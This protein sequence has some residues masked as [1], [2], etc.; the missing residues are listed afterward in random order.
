MSLYERNESFR[1]ESGSAFVNITL[2]Q[3][4]F[5]QIVLL[6]GFLQ[7]PV[8]LRYVIKHRGKLTREG[9]LLVLFFFLYCTFVVLGTWKPFWLTFCCI[10]KISFDLCHI[11]LRVDKP[12]IM[13]HCYI[14]M[15]KQIGNE[16]G[17]RMSL[18]SC[19]WI[20]FAFILVSSE[21]LEIMGVFLVQTVYTWG[22]LKITEFKV[23]TWKLS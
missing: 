9:V 20:L 1:L 14:V 19:A 15:A 10:I 16:E 22:L 12:S 21:V 8:R 5:A 4:N 11:W 2:E 7:A 3:T 6:H 23:Q 17:P 13:K 18:Y